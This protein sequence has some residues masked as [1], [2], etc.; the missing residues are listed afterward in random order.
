MDRGILPGQRGR[1]IYDSRRRAQADV[2][3]PLSEE[4]APYRRD[5]WTT[6]D[7]ATPWPL[8]HQLERE[9]GLFELDPCATSR[10][11][12]APRFYTREDDGL[13][14]PW[15]PARTFLNP[16]YSS[17]ATWIRKAIDEAAAGALV[18]CLIPSRTDQD[19]FHD[20]VLERGEV[21]FLRGRQRFIG[22]DGTPIGRPV[23]A[24]ALVIY[25]PSE[26]DM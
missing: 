16:P 11:A 17:V 4:T 19:W 18:V 6:D 15:A 3:L 12:K 24:S 21:R 2:Q 25:R 26:R 23:F 1:A 20:L 10:T 22:E 7:W 14:L 13:S 9:F 5:G 8:V